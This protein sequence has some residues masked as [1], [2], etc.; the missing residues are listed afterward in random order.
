MHISDPWI[1]WIAVFLCK[2]DGATLLE[3]AL[4]GLLVIV[5]GALALLAILESASLQRT[6]G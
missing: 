5:I 1:S 2:E 6:R 3:A 4:V